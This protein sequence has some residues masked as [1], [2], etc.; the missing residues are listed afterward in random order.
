MSEQK[1]EWTEGAAGRRQAEGG[2]IREGCA[3]QLPDNDKGPYRQHRTS[4]SDG[5]NPRTSLGARGILRGERDSVGNEATSGFAWLLRGLTRT[6]VS[7]DSATGEP[8]PHTRTAGLRHHAAAVEVLRMTRFENGYAKVD[9]AEQ[10]CGSVSSLQSL[11]SDVSCALKS[12]RISAIRVLLMSCRSE[13]V[14]PPA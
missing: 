7:R 3:L 1:V 12:P 10:C 11:D 2:G 6:G 5:R 4:R 9:L 13:F 8:V 14:A